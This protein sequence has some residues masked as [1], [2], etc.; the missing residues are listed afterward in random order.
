MSWLKSSDTANGHPVPL[1]PLMWEPEPGWPAEGPILALALEGFVHR[2]ATWAAGKGTYSIPD[3]IVLRE[4]HSDLRTS[5]TLA[6]LAARAG[7]WDRLAEDTGWLLIDDSADLYHIRT[8]AEKQWEADRKANSRDP[9]LTVKVRVRDGDACRFCGDIVDWK[10]RGTARAGTYHHLTPGE[11]ALTPDDLVVACTACNSSI[12]DDAHALAL[13]P[14]PAE[15]WYSEHS[16]TWLTTKHRQDVTASAGP[17]PRTQRATAP[18]D[19]APSGTP[20]A[21]PPRAGHRASTTPRPAPRPDTAP[22]TPDGTTR[23]PDGHRDARPIKITDAP[24]PRRPADQPR[25]DLAAPAGT[26]PAS[27][28]LSGTGRDGSGGPALPPTRRERHPPR[29]RARRG[30]GKGTRGST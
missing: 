5:R 19:P 4:S 18:S 13:M 15:P 6:Q 26:Q 3:E 14:P 20:L 29:K 11:K 30:R 2:C 12:R 8:Q 1:R 21:T 23:L 24:A 17:P 22:S 9:R 7:Y 10:A 25:T 28:S 27:P 16:A